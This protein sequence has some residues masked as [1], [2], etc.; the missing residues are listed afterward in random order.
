M[1]IS[2]ADRL[3]MAKIVQFFKDHEVYCTDSANRHEDD[4]NWL[5]PFAT[6]VIDGEI[7]LSA[8]LKLKDIL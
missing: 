4:D 8:L 6:I 2:D 3:H 7:P 5:D 1:S